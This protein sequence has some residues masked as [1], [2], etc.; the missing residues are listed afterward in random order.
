MHVSSKARRYAKALA[1][2]AIQHKKEITIGSELQALAAVFR[3]NRL[4]RLILESPAS[5]RVQQERVLDGLATSGKFSDYT[6][7]F[8]RLL[9]EGRRFHLFREMVDAYR[10]QVDAYHDRVE[11]QVTSAQPLSDAQRES[12]RGT[13][14]RNVVGGKDVQLDLKVDPALIAGVITR[15]GSV[16]YDGSLDHQLSQLRQ[17]LTAE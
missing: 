15:I 13:L 9:V 5:S 10:Q 17:R 2:V 4:A 1:R 14:Q 3:E 8:L 7:R 12:L 16:V 6:I 11:V